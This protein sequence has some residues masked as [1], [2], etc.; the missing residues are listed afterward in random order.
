MAS[1]L[2]TR[3]RLLG[4]TLQLHER[5]NLLKLQTPARPGAVVRLVDVPA[6]RRRVKNKNHGAA[7]EAVRETRRAGRRKHRPHSFGPKVDSSPRP[8]PPSRRHQHR[9]SCRRT[10]PPAGVRGGG[11]VFR[12]AICRA[13]PETGVAPFCARGLK[14]KEQ[15]LLLLLLLA[16]AAAGA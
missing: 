6:S 9:H 2:L 11:G 14:E 10:R 15:T 12:S 4:L 5:E 7:R 16:A 1:L 3:S 13:E 8:P